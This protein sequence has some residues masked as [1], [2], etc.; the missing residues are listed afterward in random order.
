MNISEAIFHLQKLEALHGKVEVYFD[1][2]KCGSS[3]TPNTAVAVAVHMAT[4][5]MR[6]VQC[7]IKEG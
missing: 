7:Q 4:E 6:R 3:F 5:P 1:C 2:P